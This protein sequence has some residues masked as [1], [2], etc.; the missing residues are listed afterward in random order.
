MKVKKAWL[1]EVSGKV[2]HLTQLEGKEM[3]FA[4]MYPL[5]GCS[6][7]EHVGL[8]KGVDM[9][10]DEEGL[11]TYEPVLNPL[12]TFLMRRAYP[13]VDPSDIGIVGNVIVTDNTKAG[14]FIS[15]EQNAPDAARLVA[16]MK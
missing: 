14:E 9:W 15:K 5:I 1:I 12:A 8:G 4:T 13:H 3:S 10:C 16:A 2:T 7:I 6:T 11:M